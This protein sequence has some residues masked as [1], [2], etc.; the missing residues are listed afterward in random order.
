MQFQAI[1]LSV[2]AIEQS[3][4]VYHAVITC[5]QTAM[6]TNCRVF[7]FTHMPASITLLKLMKLLKVNHDCTCISN[8]SCEGFESNIA[9]ELQD[10][11]TVL[12]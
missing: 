10:V 7:S 6:I 12:T 9:R 8:I 1:A 5:N 2:T 3:S 11:T 4:M